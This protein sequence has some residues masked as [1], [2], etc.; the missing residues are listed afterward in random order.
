MDLRTWYSTV[1]R[2]CLTGMP[3]GSSHTLIWLSLGVIALLFALFNY[4]SV[5]RIVVGRPMRSRELQAS[6]NKLFWLIALPILSADLYSSVAYGPEA[7][8]TELAF[9]GARAEW[10][11]V[12]IV[13][14]TVLLLAIIVTSYI[15]G[16]L[17]YPNGG[18]GYSIARDNFKQPWV[19]LVAAS[20]LLIDYVLTVAVSVSAGIQ[21]IASAYPMVAPYAA[22]LSL[23]CVLVILLVNLRGVSESATVFAWPTFAFMASMLILIAVGLGNGLTHGFVQSTTPVFGAVP[24]GLTTLIMLK[25]FS[26]ACSSLTG[27][28][29]ISNAVP[30]F[31]EPRQKSAIKAYLAMTVLT[32]VTLIGFGYELYVKGIRVNPTNTML[33]QLAAVYFGHGVMYQIITWTTFLVLIIAANS[34]FNGFPQLLALAASDGFLPHALM[35]RGDRLGYSNGMMVLATLAS[36]LIIAFDAQTNALIP[37]FAIGVFMSFTI[38]QIGLV[39]RWRRIRGR[40]WMTKAVINAVGAAVTAT[41]TVVFA[42][43]KFSQGAWIVLIAMPLLVVMALSIGRYYDGVR[44]EIAIAPGV[45]PPKPHHVLTVVLVSG[46]HLVVEHTIS[47]AQSLGTEVVALYIGFD[48]ESIADLE[49][50]WA[51]WGSP[52][53]LVTLRSEYRS[54]IHPLARFVRTLETWEG[55]K[56]DHVHLILAQFVPRHWWHYLLHNQSAFL[57]R[58]WFLRNRDVVITTVPYHLRPHKA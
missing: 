48:D 47:F 34:T 44:K 24:K 53:R 40:H 58:A 19:S 15:M 55:G 49:R 46:I 4:R 50:R 32:G 3:L 37:L 30:I 39:R 26:S 42:V 16:V 54:L 22:I 14:A 8:A 10:F 51:E 41:V 56:P 20:A 7:G 17:A 52:C 38:A 35:L 45:T 27:I 11:I 2:R 31:R 29:T 36:T 18:G 5:K 12:P 21:A 13:L 43:T 28:E 9:L 1:E 33:S 6:H 57:I 23:L 25:A